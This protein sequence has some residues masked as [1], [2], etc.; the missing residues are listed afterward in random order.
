MKTYLQPNF[1]ASRAYWCIS[2]RVQIRGSRPN[3]NSGKSM[4]P[5]RPEKRNKKSLK[6]NVHLKNFRE[7]NNFT[8][9]EFF[10]RFFLP[11]SGVLKAKGWHIRW[12]E[13]KRPAS[14]RPFFISFRA[15]RDIIGSKWQLTP[16]I[17]RSTKNQGL[18]RNFNFIKN[19]K[20]YWDKYI[21]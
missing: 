8:D 6:C 20:I 5:W 13:S 2:Q 11:A 12:T 14:S 4:N 3:G 21:Y 17:N 15:S 18:F 16:T 10:P 19:P 1:Q 9:F 7:M